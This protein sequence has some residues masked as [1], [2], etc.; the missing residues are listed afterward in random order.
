MIR[1]ILVLI[2]VLASPVSAGN[3]ASV[4]GVADSAIASIDGVAG[5]AIG[6]LEGQTYN[7]GDSV[8]ADSSC[9]GFLVCQNFQTATTGYDNSESWS[10]TVGTGGEVEAADTT[11]TVLRGT[12]QLKIFAGDAGQTSFTV[13]PSF[14]TTTSGSFHFRFKAADATPAT[15]HTIAR[16]LGEDAVARFGIWLRTDG[17]IR[18]TYPNNYATSDF[19]NYAPVGSAVLQ[20][21]TKYH[22]WIDFTINGGPNNSTLSLYASTSQTKPETA[23]LTISNGD[24][25]TGIAYVDLLQSQGAT[26]YYDQVLVDNATIGSV[27]E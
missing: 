15:Q 13:S 17:N 23:A 18:V 16:G 2:L 12:Q 9:T 20:N 25:T 5:T 4:S 6:T 24:A 14:A 1:L 26:A 8:C 3:V 27:C 10:E 11:A 7:D 22:F 19:A 21:D